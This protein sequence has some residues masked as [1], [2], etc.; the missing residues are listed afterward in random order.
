MREVERTIG[1]EFV[2]GTLPTPQEICSKQLFKAIDEIEK[3]DVDEDQIACLLYTSPS[4]RG[5]DC[6]VHGGHQPP[7]RVF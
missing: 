6:S 7:L 5:P 3:V 4:P 1:K 2:D